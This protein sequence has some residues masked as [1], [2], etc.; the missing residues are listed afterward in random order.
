VAVNGSPTFRRANYIGSKDVEK[1]V[2][3]KF[4]RDGLLYPAELFQR[5]NP[6]P[7]KVAEALRGIKS[8]EREM[9]K[10]VPRPQALA[11]KPLRL[12]GEGHRQSS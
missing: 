3:M 6:N 4:E 10:P 9:A 12:L 1:R 2:V 7:Q 11:A 8:N 5:D